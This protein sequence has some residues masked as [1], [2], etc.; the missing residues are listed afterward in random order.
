[1]AN[2]L[3]YVC[4]AL[5]GAADGTRAADALGMPDEGRRN[6]QVTFISSA[7]MEEALG[8]RPRPMTIA[9]PGPPSPCPGYTATVIKL[10]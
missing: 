3:E 1:M 5:D 4:A 2:F 6:A 10:S 7:V 9:S 8:T